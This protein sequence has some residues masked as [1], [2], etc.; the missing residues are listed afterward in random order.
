MNATDI[1]A[2]AYEADLHCIPCA[3]LAFGP[4]ETSRIEFNG[5]FGYGA[6]EYLA[7]GTQIELDEHSLR[8]N[9]KDS[10]GNELGAVFADNEFEG[11][12]DCGTCRRTLCLHCG[13]VSEDASE[14]ACWNCRSLFDPTQE[15][16]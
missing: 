9:A 11:P 12:R 15:D 14:R 2:Y 6:T 10:E 7:D 5:Q 1:I 16:A 3:V 8:S 4:A 13:T